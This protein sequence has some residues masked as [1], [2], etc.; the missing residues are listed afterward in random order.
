MKYEFESTK[1]V[2]ANVST[3][4]VVSHYLPLVKKGKDYKSD[5]PFCGAKKDKFCVTSSSNKDLYK[6]FSCGEGG[7]AVEFIQKYKNVDYEQAITI[8]AE[9]GNVTHLLK[10][11]EVK[12][13]PKEKT[14]KPGPQKPKEA[15]KSFR[16]RQ[17][18]ESGLTEDDSK[19]RIEESPGNTI[20]VERYSSSTVDDKFNIVPGDDMVMHYITLQGQRMTFVREGQKFG[21]PTKREMFRVRWQIPANHALADGSIPKYQSPYGSGSPL[22]Y[23]NS[24]I[25][26]FKNKI[27]IETLYIQEGEKKADKA[28]KHGF[29]SIGITGIHNLATR[30]SGLSSDFQLL[31]NTCAIK[32]II[33]IVDSDW[34]EMSNNPDKPID[35]RPKTFR[36]AIVK[37][38]QH[39]SNFASHG[40][41]VDVFFGHVKKE[42]GC[43]GIDDLLVLKK[44]NEDEVYKDVIKT[45]GDSNGQG[46]FLN[47]YNITTRSDHFITETLHLQNVHEF[48]KH[49]L[50]ELKKRQVFLF[51]NIQYRITEDNTVEMAQPM[52]ED[53]IFFDTKYKDD[54][55]FK[56]NFRYVQAARFL[57]NR[58]FGRYRTMRDNFIFA[59]LTNGILKEVPHGDIR[60]FVKEFTENLG[61][62]ANFSVKVISEALEMLYRGGKMYLGPEALA[63]IKYLE[64]QFHENTLTSQWLFF[65][66][67]AWLITKD[68]YEAKTIS[69]TEGVI[70]ENQIKPYECSIIPNFNLSITKITPEIARG[71]SD[72]YNT[73]C[74]SLVNSYTFQPSKELYEFDF[75]RFLINTSNFYW[76]KGTEPT[77]LEAIDIEM[78]VLNKMTCIGYMLHDF[79]NPSVL[80]AVVAVD[81]KNSEVSSSFGRTGKSLIGELF[82]FVTSMVDI[83]GKRDDLTRDKFLFDEVDERTKLI[84]VDDCRKN[85]DFEAFFPAITGR[86]LSVEKKGEGKRTITNTIKFFFTTNHGIDGVGGSFY[87]R[88]SFISFSD[89]Y[90][91]NEDGTSHKP[92]D[93][94]KKA[95]FDEWDATD[96][97]RCFNFC[98]LCISLYLRHGIIQADQSRIIKRQKRQQTGEA[99]I[100]WARIYFSN[101]V[102]DA[103][104]KVGHRNERVDK[105]AA[106]EDFSSRY[107]QAAKFI[108]IR[109]FKK[110]IISYCEFEGLIFNPG[111]KRNDGNTTHDHGG[112]IKTG[113]KEYFIISDENYNARR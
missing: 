86:G 33:F 93:D 51:G 87:D 21:G 74:S 77:V 70:W 37:F 112:D 78:N 15:T 17:L 109:N 84:F 26:K 34:D 6:C 96:I 2:I 100:D 80:K 89:Y 102:D 32:R 50:E 19:I 14:N 31:I 95:F 97:N 39:F 94:F 28:T 12:E 107:K 110:K 16:D 46:K 81:G 47:I 69:N 40:I 57:Q 103:G 75:F 3:L 67:Q 10:L 13:S 49:H 108:D 63:N 101:D 25:A 56:V 106:Y 23:P 4:Q 5:C 65:K 18:I 92:I 24:I 91:H 62:G 61:G 38:K 55:S 59:K 41:H 9:I 35:A 73:D 20:E 104:N 44:G 54:G 88:I 72:R 82:R 105:E 90:Y 85:L 8:M 66:N 22:W 113:G 1:E 36:S 83:N 76:N 52:S 42:N 7:K 29:D 45:I 58:G 98:A 111:Y 71:Y 99:I 79:R 43:K 11:K 27:P 64:P 68:G 48:A 60:D 53:E 30:T